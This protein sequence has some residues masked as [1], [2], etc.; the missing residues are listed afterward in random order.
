MPRT[1]FF[2][3][4]KYALDRFNLTLSME[5]D[6]S[7][8][9][10]RERRGEGLALAI[11]VAREKVGTGVA[12]ALYGEGLERLGGGG[13]ERARQRVLLSYRDRKQF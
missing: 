12:V 8:I 10:C 11:G 2:C 6:F 5:P 3:V 4:P 13:S 7:S 1:D 9:R